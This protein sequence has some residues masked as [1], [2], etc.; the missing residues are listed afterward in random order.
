MEMK[1]IVWVSRHELDERNK[2]ILNRAFGSWELA[3]WVKDTVTPEK[4][5]ELTEEY[6]DAAFVVVLPP[7]LLAELLRYTK[8][9]YRFLVDREVNEDGTAIFTPTGLERVVRIEIVTERLV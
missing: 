4:L 2:E 6:S 5:K 9:V 7:Q 1:K 3:K 8:E